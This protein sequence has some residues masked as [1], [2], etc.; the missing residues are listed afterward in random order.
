MVDPLNIIVFEEMKVI[1]KKVI[2]NRS[3]YESSN[4]MKTKIYI[5]FFLIFACAIVHAQIPNS[6]F[7]NWTSSVS[8]DILDSWDN[9]NS[10]TAGSSVYTSEKG[11]PGATGVAGTYFI[12]LTSKTVTGQG[13]VPGI[14]VSGKLNITT[15]KPISGFAFNQRPANLTGN[16]QYMVFSAKGVINAGYIDVQLTRWDASMNMRDTIAGFHYSLPGMKMSW[17]AF[18]IPL[19]YGDSINYPDSCI[20]TLSASSTTPTN[21]DFLYIDDLAFTGTVAPVITLIPNSGFEN[22][23]N[24]GSYNSP[25]SWD[26][27]NSVTSASSVYTCEQ[28]TPGAAGTAGTSSLKLTTKTVPGIG[29]VPGI[30]VSGILNKTTLQ[31]VSGFAFNQRPASLTGNWQYM[32]FSTDTTNAGYVDVKL[33]RW[34]ASKNKRDTIAGV[35]YSLPDMI[36]NWESFSLPLTYVDNVN[37]PDSCVITLSASSTTPIENDFLYVDHLA[38][39]GTVTTDGTLSQIPNSGFENWSGSVSYEIP[40][41]W[42]NINSTTTSTGIYTCEQGTPGVSGSYYLKL[43]SK[44]ISGV[45]VVPGIAVSRTINK[46]TLQPVSGFAFNQR[47]ANLTGNWQYMVFSAKGVINAG[48]IDVQLTRWDASMNM[49]DTIASVHYSLPGMKMSWN[50]FTLPLTYVDNANYPDS[51]VITLSAS[52]L[53]PTNKDFLYVDNLA[54]SGTQLTTNIVEIRGNKKINVYPNPS[55]DKISFDLP[56]TINSEANIQ[57]LNLQG[58]I[59]KLIKNADAT[60]TL[61]VDIRDLPTG[62]YILKVILLNDVFVSRFI[63]E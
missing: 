26:N 48:Y 60:S 61:S 34:D 58:E 27:L 38:F 24:K 9:L 18:S 25:A 44:S 47:P 37:Y 59:V 42:D 29:V 56:T 19:A 1:S 8:Y 20:I 16:W 43:T 23:I 39:S 5:T 40:A 13:V 36:M 45:G 3:I 33:T 7:E 11:T 17:N 14:A 52:S 35:H 31:P 41:S 6:D 10:T 30:A 51:C 32:V 28:G 62:N 57:I 15:L 55:T 12:K 2:K 53:T 63:K 21:K 50:A 54:F 46:T 22:W 4:K 49:R